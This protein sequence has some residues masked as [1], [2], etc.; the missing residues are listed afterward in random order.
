MA[1]KGDLGLLVAVTLLVLSAALV[2]AAYPWPREPYS[3]YEVMLFDGSMY[4]SDAGRS[5]GGFEYAAEYNVSFS[6]YSWVDDS[7]P[8][9][10]GY[11]Y[12]AGD[13]VTLTFILDVGL[14]DALGVH[15]LSLT[16]DY[17]NIQRAIILEKD[18]IR[19][20]AELV[21]KDHVWGGVWDGYYI[22]SWGGDAP[23]NEVRGEISP[24]IFDLP[25][26]YYVELRLGA[27]VA[28]MI[29]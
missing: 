16:V 3:A 24:G 9:A 1:G 8:E 20:V 19:I 17:D 13:T 5:H 22:A 27:H 23:A 25:E 7:I 2:T 14:G 11:V 29:E 10:P 26:H 21:E 6:G 28:H 4:V 12:M 15:T 18:D